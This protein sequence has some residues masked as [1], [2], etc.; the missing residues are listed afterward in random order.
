MTSLSYPNIFHNLKTAVKEVYLDVKRDELYYEN[1]VPSREE[2]RDIVSKKEFSR[3]PESM[4][5]AAREAYETIHHTG[6]GQLCDVIIDAAC[7]RAI[8]A[9]RDLV[10]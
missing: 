2:L 4:E 9:T 6:D 1:T 8:D 5:A 10:R 7:L 3:L